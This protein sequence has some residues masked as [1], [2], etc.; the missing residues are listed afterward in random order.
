MPLGDRVLDL[1]LNVIDVEATHIYLCHTLPTTFT[2]ASSTYAVA[3]KNFGA[4]AVAGAP[5]AAAPN[6]RKVTTAAVADGSITATN[7]S[8]GA[9]FWAIT[10]NANSRLLAAYSLAAA[11]P[12]TSGGS[13]SLPAYDVRIPNQ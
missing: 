11:Q 6:G 2:E 9:G 3:N 4:G 13:F 12:V 1:G 8:P 7:A 5:A 10:D